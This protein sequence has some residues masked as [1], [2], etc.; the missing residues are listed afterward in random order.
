MNRKSTFVVVVSSLFV[1]LFVYTAISKWLDVDSFK[2]VIAQSPLIGSFS[3]IL[4][5]LLP[6]LELWIA[7]LLLCK[8]TRRIGLYAALILMLVFTSYIIYL[9]LFSSHLPC[10]CGG[11]LKYLSWRT[12]LLFNLGWILLAV[13][14]IK[15]YAYKDVS[16]KPL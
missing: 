8:F 9:L 1:L 3:I 16:R 6:A 7:G 13:A 5:W 4:S 15:L 12:H 2:A 14:A 10:S 11:V